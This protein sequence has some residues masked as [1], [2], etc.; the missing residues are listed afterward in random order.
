MDKETGTGRAYSLADWIG[1]TP[2]PDLPNGR[3]F[4]GLEHFGSRAGGVAAFRISDGEILWESSDAGFTHASPTYRPDSDTVFCGSNSGTFRCLR[5]EDG[6][7][8]WRRDFGHPIKIRPTVSPDGSKVFFGC[9]DGMLRCL[10]ARDGRTLWE[11]RTPFNA[12]SEALGGE[13]GVFV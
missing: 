5:A 8:L 11:F 6:S 9:F 7:V 13:D 12:Y 1:S 3:A 10:D 4:V 2:F